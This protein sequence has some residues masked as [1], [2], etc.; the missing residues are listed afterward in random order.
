MKID[1]E[2]DDISLFA[3]VAVIVD[4]PKI[5]E[6]ILKLRQKW[7]NG[8][9]Y[10][11]AKAWKDEGLKIN[12]QND[13][14]DL[15]ESERIS[16]VFLSVIEEAMVTNKVTHFNRVV[17]VPIPRKVL[18]EYLIATYDTLDNGDYEYV[19]VT[20]IEAERNEVEEGY[21][22]MKRAVK[23]TKEIDN[24]FEQLLQPLLQNPKTSFRN[25]REWY[26]MYQQEKQNGKGAYKRI[27]GSWDKLHPPKEDADYL[28]Q[29]VIEQAVSRYSKLLKR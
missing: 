9:T 6:G 27:V 7:T 15:L 25:A 26:W 29:N 5:L 28:D 4:R 19:L 18:A 13:I 3:Q 24:P 12:Y 2:I 22:N 20:P 14:I 11:S 17:M 23:K 21:A 10:P 1:I 8:K 16:P